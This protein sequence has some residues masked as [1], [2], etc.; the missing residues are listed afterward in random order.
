MN[1]TLVKAANLTMVRQFVAG[2]GN[3]GQFEWLSDSNINL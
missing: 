1:L 3:P 2:L